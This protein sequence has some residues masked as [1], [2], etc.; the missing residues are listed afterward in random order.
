MHWAPLFSLPSDSDSSVS[1]KLYF[2]INKCCVQ[3]QNQQKHFFSWLWDSQNLEMTSFCTSSIHLFIS[4]VSV[5][6]QLNGIVWCFCY[7]SPPGSLLFI[8]YLVSNLLVR[9]Q[10]WLHVAESR[11]GTWL[12]HRSAELARSHTD[13]HTLKNQHAWQWRNIYMNF[14]TSD[15]THKQSRL[16]W[17]MHI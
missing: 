16:T 1:Q 10:V 5:S 17:V 6:L 12:L 2:Y 4:S 14:V 11:G 15:A 9:E 7:L 3:T 8:N 13:T